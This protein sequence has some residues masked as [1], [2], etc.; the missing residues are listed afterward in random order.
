VVHVVTGNELV[1]V[2]GELQAGQIRDS[3]S[4]LM[5]ALLRESGSILVN[6]CRTGD[7]MVAVLDAIRS[8]GDGEWDMLLLSGGAGG[9]DFDF[10][11][12]TLESLGFA[13]HFRTVNLRPGK[14]LIFGTRGNQVAF[15]IPGN[16]VSHLVTFHLV[17]RLA[18]EV[19]MGMQEIMKWADPGMETV[20]LPL[21]KSWKSDRDRRESWCP[22]RVE[23]V[24]GRIVVEPVVWQNS[25]DL[26]GLVGVNALVRVR[27]EVEAVDGNGNVECLLLGIRAFGA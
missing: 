23:T 25:G 21:K 2:S 11:A 19:F 1:G 18:L 27:P 16:P 24:G 5:G 17:I 10:G 26:C 20:R 15:V 12:R 22:A 14:P 4:S 7:S 3:N 9:G 6:Q 8:V 13:L